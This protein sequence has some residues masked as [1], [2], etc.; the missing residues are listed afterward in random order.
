MF[1]TATTAA[2]AETTTATATT[3]TNSIMGIGWN[4]THGQGMN[5][6]E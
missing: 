2:T 5:E 3:V 4:T 6:K 1:L